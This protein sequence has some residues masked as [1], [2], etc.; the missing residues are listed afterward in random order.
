MP[1]P[2]R[3]IFTSG[4]ASNSSAMA[5]CC[6]EYNANIKAVLPH[7]FCALMSA[8]GEPVFTGSPPGWPVTLIRPDTPCA[9]VCQ[10]DR[11]IGCRSLTIC[12]VENQ[13][14]RQKYAEAERSGRSVLLA[15]NLIASTSFNSKEVECIEDGVT[16]ILIER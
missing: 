11:Q 8:T 13:C 15:T 2:C 9:M 4:C 16:Q 10:C 6:P 12:R 5:L 1:E 3:C 7:V 14:C